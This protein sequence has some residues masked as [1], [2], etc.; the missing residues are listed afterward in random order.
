MNFL[1]YKNNK[2]K[3]M[4]IY[5][6]PKIV[7][8]NSKVIFSVLVTIKV[9]QY[10]DVRSP[11]YH[12]GSKMLWPSWQLGFCSALS[13]VPFAVALWI[14]SETIIAKK[15]HKNSSLIYFI[16]MICITLI[17]ILWRSNFLTREMYWNRVLG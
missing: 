14:I 16:A 13:T 4:H 7:L 3:S 15:Q 12:C 2:I 6:L 9:V 10:L 1:N 17:Y 8:R 5:A 11:I